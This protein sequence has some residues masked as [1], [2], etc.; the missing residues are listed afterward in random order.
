MQ[1][2][3]RNATT[4]REISISELVTSGVLSESAV[5][6]DGTVNEASRIIAER[7]YSELHRPLRRIRH[8]NMS[9]PRNITSTPRN[10]TSTPRNITSTPRNITSTP[11]A[12]TSRFAASSRLI[13]QQIGNNNHENTQNTLNTKA[14]QTD[15]IETIDTNACCICLTQPREF[16]LIPCFHLCVCVHCAPRLDTCPLCREEIYTYCKIWM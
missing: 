12:T 8:Q 14:V 3:V 13:C 1:G 6:N 10:I 7:E 2:E 4:P 11:N 5:R 16:A 9:T 15:N